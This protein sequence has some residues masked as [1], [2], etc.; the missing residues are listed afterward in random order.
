MVNPIPLWAI[1][2][3]NVSRCKKSFKDFDQNQRREKVN[4]NAQPG[5][6]KEEIPHGKKIFT[7]CKI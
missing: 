6:V 5:K 7:W 2:N 3:G 1:E 4:E